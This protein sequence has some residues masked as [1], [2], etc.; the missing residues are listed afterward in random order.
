MTSTSTHSRNPW[1]STVAIAAG[2]FAVVVLSLGTDQLLH[3]LNVYPP[4]GEPMYEPGLN[5]LA[6]AYRVVY[7]I[8]GSFIAARLAPR[9]PMW[10]AL[11]LGVIGTVLSLGGV[12]AAIQVELGPIWYP[13]G[14]VI[15]AMPCAWL[16]GVLHQKCHASKMG[17]SS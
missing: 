16:G 2:F 3:M 12:V 15:T 8:L 1:K 13:I 14:I 10:H 6:L 17:A 7:T 5:A 9:A 11:L 4:W